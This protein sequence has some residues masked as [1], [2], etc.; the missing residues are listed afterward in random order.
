MGQ[1]HALTWF[2]LITTL[3]MAGDVD[4]SLDELAVGEGVCGV[5]ILVE[6]RVECLVWYAFRPGVEVG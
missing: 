5:T 6:E 2:E 4:S 3:D 1:Q